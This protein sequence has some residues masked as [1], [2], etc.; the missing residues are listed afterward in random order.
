MHRPPEQE[1]TSK[2]K[3]KVEELE[4][5]IEDDLYTEEEHKELVEEAL[6]QVPGI[7]LVGSVLEAVIGFDGHRVYQF[8]VVA[9]FHEA[10]HQPVPVVRRFNCYGLDAFLVRFQLRQY[11]WQVVRVAVL[12]DN[13]VLLIEHNQHAV[14][15]MQ[16]DCGV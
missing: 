10:V 14:I 6:R 9:G 4:A 1:S 16:V 2:A 15:G 3:E 11:G 8:Y 12:V 7:V 13:F 5:K